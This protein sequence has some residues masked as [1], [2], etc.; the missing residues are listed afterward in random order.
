MLKNANKKIERNKGRRRDYEKR[1]IE[2]QTEGIEFE[3]IED[4]KEALNDAREKWEIIKVK[5]GELREKELM[6][7]NPVELKREDENINRRKKKY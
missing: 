6:D 5:G 7:Y 4:A 1:Q 2:A 3:L